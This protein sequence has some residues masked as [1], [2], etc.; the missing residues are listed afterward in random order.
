M[1]L[2]CSLDKKKIILSFKFSEY[3]L[4]IEHKHINDIGSFAIF[5]LRA[6]RDNY[7]INQI[8]QITKNWSIIWKRGAKSDI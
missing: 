8:S 6:F 5:C 7:S 4:Q 1:S 2:D 3:I